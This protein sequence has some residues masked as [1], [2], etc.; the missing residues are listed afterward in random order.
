MDKG[1]WFLMG[2]LV[3][4]LVTEMAIIIGYLNWSS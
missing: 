4:V 3:G 1:W 2:V